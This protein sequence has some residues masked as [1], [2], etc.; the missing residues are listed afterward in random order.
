VATYSTTRFLPRILETLSERYGGNV[1]GAA[2]IIFSALTVA[3]MMGAVKELSTSYSIWQIL[4]ARYI[5]QFL[6]LAPLMIRSRGSIL[7]SDRI[8]LQMLR[9]ALAFVG[10]VCVFY[11][12]VQ[13]P[14]A[15]AS[16]L[17]FSQ[18]IFV[19]ALAAII[20][21]E[22]VGAIGWTATGI[23][24]A[25]VTIML[26]PTSEV[27]NQ[28]ALVG[29]GGAL[30]NAGVV[31]TV[32]KLTATDSTATIMSYPAIGLGLLFVIP[33]SLTWQPITWDVAPLFAL[34]MISGAVTT[35][36]FINSYR[37]GE[38][39]IMATVEYSRLV[40]AALVGFIVFHEIPTTG[41]LIGIALI[42]LASF[43]AVKRDQIRTRLSR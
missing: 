18:T 26:D 23:G 32:K 42:V 34:I 43:I 28:A 22:K 8:D 5:G 14:L 7:K 9:V 13:L 19:V 3:S 4:L 27:L 24:V 41:A 20:F 30:A 6:F 2:L 38:A 21:A 33:G 15:E 25:G 16:A 37:H 40:A 10:I 29:V 35:W 17:G 1:V 36:C 11:A 31:I 12:I 39:S